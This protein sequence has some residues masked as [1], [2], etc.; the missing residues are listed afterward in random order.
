MENLLPLLK[1]AHKISETLDIGSFSQ[2]EEQL[3]TNRLI[4]VAE[5]GKA[6]CAFRFSDIADHLPRMEHQHM[7]RACM[8]Q[9][10]AKHN[11]N[12]ADRERPVGPNGHFPD[13]IVVSGWAM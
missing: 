1:C 6:E 4:L 2:S 11:L 9:L 5:A 12:M 13:D 7:F 8:G 3:I 10:C